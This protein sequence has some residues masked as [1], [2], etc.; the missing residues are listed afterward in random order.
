MELAQGSHPMNESSVLES[1][2]QSITSKPLDWYVK[3]Q[4]MTANK[5]YENFSGDQPCNVSEI[6]PVLIIRADGDADR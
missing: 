1:L 2:K 4:A 5:F 3:P 6:S